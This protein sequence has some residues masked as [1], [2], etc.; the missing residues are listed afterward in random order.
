MDCLAIAGYSALGIFIGNLVGW[1]VN[2]WE[3]QTAKGYTALIGAVA[4]V[5]SIVP[6]F[7]PKVGGEMW[8]YPIF[9][10]IGL[11]VSPLLD[12]AFSWFYGLPSVKAI[13][14]RADDGSKVR[15]KKKAKSSRV[16]G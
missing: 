5:A 2:T 11:L 15:V 14:E 16:S 1:A 4:G 13:H 9:L 7:S 6:L 8:F 10:L 3:G 12:L